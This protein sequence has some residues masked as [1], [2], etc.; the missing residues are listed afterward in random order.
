MSPVAATFEAAAAFIE[1]NT[2][3]SSPPACPEIRLWTATEVTP[4]WEATEEALLRVNL[5][6]PYWAFCWAGGQALT[7]WVLDNSDLVA[8]KRVLDF[9]AGSGVSAIGAALRG[10]AK[11]EAAEIDPMACYAIEMNA[12]L[13]SVTV[14]TLKDDVVGAPCRWDVVLAGDVCYEAP[15]TAHIW[16]WLVSLAAAGALVV[17]ADPGRAY[18]PKTGLLKVAQYTVRTSLEL[19]DRVQRD[20]VVFKIVG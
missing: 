19:E 5:P 9:A 11:V 10:A 17:M 14:E 8:G 12:K 2:E 1:A 7:R 6:P 4:L 15:M 18:L 20:V 3:I 13:N 16:P